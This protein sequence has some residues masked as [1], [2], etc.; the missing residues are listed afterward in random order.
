LRN[1]TGSILAMK[2]KPVLS[3]DTS[4]ECVRG[5]ENS[6]DVPWT[7]NPAEMVTKLLKIDSF[8]TERIHQAANEDIPNTSEGAAHCKALIEKI[9]NLVLKRLKRY[10]PL[11]NAEQQLLRK[12]IKHHALMVIL[13]LSF[14]ATGI[15]RVV[16]KEYDKRP[17]RLMINANP[18]TPCSP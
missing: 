10:K 1:D 16:W 11:L 6:R 4:D 5:P 13:D 2:T 7:P 8:L 18:C 9:E 15:A 3:V 12:A 17:V 14:R